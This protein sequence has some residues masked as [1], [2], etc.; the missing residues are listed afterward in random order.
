MTDPTIDVVQPQT[1]PI[2]GGTL[3]TITGKN[4]DSV[5]KCYIDGTECVIDDSSLSAESFNCLTAPPTSGTAGCKAI[6][7]KDINDR[8]ILLSTDCGTGAQSTFSF[9]GQHL[10][11]ALV[12]ASK[13]VVWLADEVSQ[14][15]LLPAS[16]P[17]RLS[18]HDGSGQYA[19][20]PN[21]N[22]ITITGTGEEG[23]R[24]L[25]LCVRDVLQGSLQMSMEL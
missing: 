4:V 15:S 7:L 25:V 1:G 23:F 11:P 3:L 5:D 13:C 16:G 21:Q 24:W 12:Y 20:Y 17:T 22:R 18:I 10:L 14:A 2:G 19:E 6:E 8:Q 9:Y